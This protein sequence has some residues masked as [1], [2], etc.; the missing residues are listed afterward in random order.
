MTD[1]KNVFLLIP[2]SQEAIDLDSVE[3]VLTGYAQAGF[4]E[5]PV[6][7]EVTTSWAPLESRVL[8][9]K[10]EDYIAPLFIRRARVEDH[11]DLVAVFNAQSDVTTNVYG[12]YFL[13]ELVEAQN[14]E[15]RAIVAEVDGRA[16]GLMCLTSD[17]DINVLAQCFELDPYDQ[18]LKPKYMEKVRKQGDNP[19]PAEIGDYVQV[20]VRNVVLEDLFADAPLEDGEYHSVALLQHLQTVEFSATEVL[21]GEDTPELNL[22]ELLFPMIWQVNWRGPVPDV[23]STIKPETALGALRQVEALTVEQRKMV[24]GE[25][26]ARWDAVTKCFEFVA[27]ETAGLQDEEEEEQAEEAERDPD[28]TPQAA[29]LPFLESLLQHPPIPYDEQARLEEQLEEQKRNLSQEE[30]ESMNLQIPKDPPVLGENEIVPLVLSLHWWGRLKITE[31]LGTFSLD[32]LKTAAEQVM[33]GEDELIWVNRPT[34]PMW[35]SNVPQHA[36]DA[37]CINLFC[38]DASSQMQAVDFLLPAFSLYPE[39]DI[40]VLTQPHTCTLA[41]PKP[42]NTFDHALFLV[43]RSTLLSPPVLRTVA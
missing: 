25:L 12:E 14:D 17:V 1:L 8:A 11:D 21:G 4:T 30:L 27:D 13:A 37:F 7:K 43:H 36:K 28:D 18:L 5:L 32:E 19:P 35:L 40:C 23:R 26:L 24:C 16:V 29:W 41:P 42:T 2:G 38:L 34:S 9:A 33:A 3:K 15:N 6:V 10:R 39:K 20:A 22:A 31:P